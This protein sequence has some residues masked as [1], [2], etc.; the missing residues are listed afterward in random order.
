MLSPVEEE[1][2]S[3]WEGISGDGEDEEMGK[4]MFAVG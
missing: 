2:Y 1:G 3:G 4:K